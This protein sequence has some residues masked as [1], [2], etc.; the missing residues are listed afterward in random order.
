M[1]RFMGLFTIIPAT[2]LLTVS[3][4]VIF[5]LGKLT[6]K[7]LRNFGIAIV[8]L[9]WFSAAL[10]FCLGIYTIVTGEHPMVRMHRTMMKNMMM[11][12]GKMSQGD[13]M[14]RPDVM[15]KR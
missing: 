7:Q 13:R 2:V 1:I 3:F 4:F 5:T 10:I 12:Q 14:M 6:S 11:Q 15:P 8:I 9:L